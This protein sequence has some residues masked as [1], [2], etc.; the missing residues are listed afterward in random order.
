MDTQ[1]YDGYLEDSD[2]EGLEFQATLRPY[3]IAGWDFLERLSQT[4]EN[5]EREPDEEEEEEEEEEEVVEEEQEEDDD[6][7]DRVA[8][9]EETPII[10]QP[11]PQLPPGLP[12]VPPY[13]PFKHPTPLHECQIHLPADFDYDNPGVPPFRPRP[14]P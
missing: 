3:D 14:H 5:G 7:E 6:D 2:V 10:V 8:E 9:R 11:Q 13:T 1:Y 4:T 12:P